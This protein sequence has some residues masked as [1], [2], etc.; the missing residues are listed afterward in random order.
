MPLDLPPDEVRAFATGQAPAPLLD[1][2]GAMATHAVAAGLRTGVFDALA[3]GPCT[4]ADLAARL[5]A[6]TEGLARLLDLLR[7]TGYVELHDGRY[8][9]SPTATAWLCSASPSSYGQ[10]LLVWQSI[11]GDLWADLPTAVQTGRPRGDFYLWLAERPELSARF[12]DLQ[13]GL[14]GWLAE[15][16]VALAPPP[17]GEVRLLDLGGGHGTYSAA[18][19][20]THPQLSATVVDLPGALGDGDH[21]RIRWVAADLTRDPIEGKHDMV[22]LCNVL[23]GFPAAQAAEIVAKAADATRPGGQVLVLE[24]IA[25][26]RAGVAEGAFT[27]GFG[28]NLWHTQGGGVPSTRT[29]DGWL[30]DA[31][32][33]QIK[34]HDLSRSATHSL[35]VGTR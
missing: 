5:G 3:E 6:G 17:D 4:P 25:E 8:A 20:R 32:L 9:N 31:G 21:E 30:A 24:T 7:A 26:H 23:H 15:E 11:L 2:V 33:G 22:L 13:R 34:R 14:A 16:V 10:V 19:C 27:A 12:Q 29:V 28:L 18:F 1:L 35:F